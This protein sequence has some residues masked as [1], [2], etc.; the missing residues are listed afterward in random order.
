L[1]RRKITGYLP[2]FFEALRLYSI[3]VRATRLE[4]ARVFVAQGIYL[5]TIAGGRK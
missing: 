2:L 1:P 3:A 4:M 5:E